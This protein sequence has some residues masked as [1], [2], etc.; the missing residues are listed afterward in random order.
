MKHLSEFEN[1]LIAEIDRLRDDLISDIISLIKIP[2]VK[3][4]AKADAPYG[5][6]PKKALEKAME[7]AKREGL[8]CHFVGNH[9]AYSS[10]G[11][12]DKYIGIFGHLD[13]VAAGVEK[14]WTYPPFAGD[15]VA[16]RI[17]GRGAL[18][19]KGPSMAAFYALLA[20]K[21]LGYSFNH[22]VRM[23]FGSDEESGMSDLR[24][25]LSK[26]KPPLMGFVPDNKF[27]AIFAERGRAEFEITGDGL[28]QFYRDLLRDK[29]KVVE[30]LELDFEDKTF[31]Q[32]L[33]KLAE[34]NNSTIRLVL[35]TPEI[36]IDD[37]TKKIEDKAK[38]INVKLVKYYGP[39]RKS[40]DSLLV[41]RLNQ[42]YNDY[43]GDNISPN[44][45]TGMTYAHY[46][47]NVIGFGPSFPGQNGIAHLPDEWIDIDDLLD[48]AKI[49]AI[50]IY[51]LDKLKR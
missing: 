12:S 31:G 27:P 46:C 24:Y 5:P 44:T 39:A 15:I 35:S 32:I 41:S 42:V 45:T 20:L 17:Y 7:I 10:I 29:N 9:M 28:E 26:E 6:Y 40:R 22:Q 30:K 33:V 1:K 49:Y 47:P 50:G 13:V 38:D 3:G 34:K 51:R 48:M 4:E 37:L 36:E 8:E 16:N 14:K 19:N 43:T 23:V 11:N 21:N 18:D 25:Y 2:S